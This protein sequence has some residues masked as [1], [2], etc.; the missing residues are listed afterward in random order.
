MPLMENTNGVMLCGVNY[1][2]FGG[3]TVALVVYPPLLPLVIA[4]GSLMAMLSHFE[5]RSIC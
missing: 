4:L 5:T 3:L 2:M 1:L